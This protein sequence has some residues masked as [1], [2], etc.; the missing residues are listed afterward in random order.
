LEPGAGGGEFKFLR[1]F[2]PFLIN[3]VHYFTSSNMQGAVSDFLEQERE[4]NRKTSDYLLLNSA[5]GGG[6]GK[7][8]ADDDDE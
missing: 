1:G 4:S 7:Q 5:V 8:T 2:D 3:S 6:G